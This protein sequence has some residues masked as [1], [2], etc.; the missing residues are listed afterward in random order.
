MKKS[1]QNE[2]PKLQSVPVYGTDRRT[3]AAAAKL[4]AKDYAIG[5]NYNPTS[6]HPTT[7]S[8]RTKFMQFFEAPSNYVTLKISEFFKKYKSYRI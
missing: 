3:T 7:R 6:N 4:L 1:T 2:S 8:V 5:A